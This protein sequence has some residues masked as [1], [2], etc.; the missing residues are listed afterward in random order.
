MEWTTGKMGPYEF[1]D[2]V[3]GL[4]YAISILVILTFHEFGHY[5]AAVYHKV[6]ATLPYYIPFP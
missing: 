2:M 1:S 6:K 4:P 5:F 3:K